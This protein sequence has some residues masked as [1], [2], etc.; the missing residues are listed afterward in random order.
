MHVAA[1]NYRDLKRADRQD[2]M[3]DNSGIITTL[4]HEKSRNPDHN[5][6]AVDRSSTGYCGQSPSN[7]LAFRLTKAAD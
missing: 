7:N 3:T 2:E 5:D 4:M 6:V 1:L